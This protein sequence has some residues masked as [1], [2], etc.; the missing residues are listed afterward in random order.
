M[1]QDRFSQAPTA[2]FWSLYKP[3]MAPKTHPL[4]PPPAGDNTIL[5]RWEMDDLSTQGSAN[6]EQGTPNAEV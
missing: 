6:L 3:P 4:D 5:A 1:K 2:G